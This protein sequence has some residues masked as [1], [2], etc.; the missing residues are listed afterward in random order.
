[1]LLKIYFSNTGIIIL[2]FHL[3]SL[4]I[5]RQFC[6]IKLQQMCNIPIF[7]TYLADLNFYFL[8][9]KSL[10]TSFFSFVEISTKCFI[11]IFRE[12]QKRNVSESRRAIYICDRCN[13][14]CNNLEEGPHATCRFRNEASCKRLDSGSLRVPMVE[15]ESD[16]GANESIG[17][18][19]PL[20]DI[21]NRL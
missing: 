7:R 3:G 1:M 19:D 9:P 16:R 18:T 5:I 8:I 10:S 13:F 15:I 20:L 4:I 12:K 6:V 2:L 21:S 14:S 11:L 17:D